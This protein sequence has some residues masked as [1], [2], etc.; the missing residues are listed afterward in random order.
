MKYLIAFLIY[1]SVCFSQ[2]TVHINIK[3]QRVEMSQ[4]GD[5]LTITIQELAPKQFDIAPD[6]KVVQ[7][8]YRWLQT[9]R[10]ILDTCGT[11]IIPD[12][13]DAYGVT[14]ELMNNLVPCATL[15]ERLFP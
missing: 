14:L 12:A 9:P 1:T 10:I 4:S 6:F 3:T 13:Q 7:P 2:T 15:N 11:L 8:S 5:T